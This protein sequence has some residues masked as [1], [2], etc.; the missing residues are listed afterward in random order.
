MWEAYKARRKFQ[1]N[2]F[3]YAPNG[4]CE[5]STNL[6]SNKVTNRV[7][8]TG[9]NSGESVQGMFDANPCQDL[10]ICHGFTGTGCTC[11]DSGYCGSTG[12]SGACG[13]E[14]YMYGG[15]VWVVRENDPR[16]EYMLIRR[17]AVWDP[18]VPT[19]DALIEKDEKYKTLAYS[20]PKADRVLFEP[21][22]QVIIASTAEQGEDEPVPAIGV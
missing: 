17:F 9:D 7:K 18:A 21:V 16:K 14:S 5:C 12:G 13:I 3:V 2:G 11:G 22:G 19:G 8:L 4:P 15:D 1:Y 10:N 6:G 20:E